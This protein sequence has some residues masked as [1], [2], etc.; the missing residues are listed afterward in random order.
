MNN[1]RHLF[2]A[3]RDQGVR[4]LFLPSSLPPR[5][6]GRSLVIVAIGCVLLVGAILV[7]SARLAGPTTPAPTS[8]RA[9]PPTSTPVVPPASTD[10]PATTTSTSTSTSTEPGRDSLSVTSGQRDL[11]SGVARAFVAAWLN[12]GSVD[13]RTVALAPYTSAQLLSQVVGIAPGALPVAVVQSVGEV[14]SD[15]L[16]AV[17]SVRLTNGLV[18][19]VE[20]VET[21][22]GWQVVSFDRPPG[23]PER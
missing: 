14:D 23:P 12:P 5:V 13:Q 20:L 11:V 21:A 8:S 6:S 22:A 1:K 10:R 3:R 2:D 19:A 7:D 9:T 17:V 4:P 18:V 15:G 16:R